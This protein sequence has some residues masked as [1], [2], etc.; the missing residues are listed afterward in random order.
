MHESEEAM[1]LRHQREILELENIHLNQKR[2]MWDR[3]QNIMSG[4]STLGMIPNT[5]RKIFRTI[6][7]DSRRI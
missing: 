4:S 5:L 1:N 2:N 3:R 7:S 6:S